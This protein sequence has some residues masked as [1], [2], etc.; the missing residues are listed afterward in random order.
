M[1]IGQVS[2]KYDITKDNLY[3][4][5]NYGL[6]VPGKKG[7]QYDFDAQTLEDLERIL[8]LKDMKF[9]LKQIHNILSLYRISGLRDPKDAED[10][11]RIY[12]EQLNSLNR[13][14]LKTDQRIDR[15]E[16]MIADID[17]LNPRRLDFTGVP[18]SM[19][20][21]LCCPDCGKDFELF[22]VEMDQRYIY[23]AELRCSCG[24]QASISDGIL[25]TPNK[26][27]DVYDTPDI[28]RDMYKNLPPSLISLFQ[29]SYNWMDEK[30]NAL[31]LNN[32][33][34][35]ETYVNAWC[36][37]H[38]HQKTLD[39]TGK[40]IIVDKYP[41][42]LAMYKD[43]IEKQGCNPN[44]LYIADSSTEFPLKKGII[45]VCIDYFAVNEHN[46]YHES[47]LYD[48]LSVFFNDDTLLL[49]TYFYFDKGVQSMK[50][51]LME[52][53]TVSKN[54]FNIQYFSE[55]MGESILE[56]ED[57]GY[58]ESSGDNIGFSFHRDGE[59]MYLRSYLAKASHIIQSPNKL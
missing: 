39:P 27:T 35:I 6:L 58:T 43:I 7:S 57:C 2:K 45:D 37:M 51:L 16:K 33:V 38:N 48:K 24:Y 12:V 40:Y 47:F 10:L 21:C 59:K 15:L 9:S 42:T 20:H 34:V 5:I 22:N 52:Y 50:T 54:N 53:P 31:D 44:I 19:M 46:F 25:L 32:K 1:K 4:Y 14:R 13:E 49:G 30:L 3:Y 36:Y 11:K 55:K 23:N 41:E 17:S 8:Q 56:Y 26:N 28:N 18:L 29:I